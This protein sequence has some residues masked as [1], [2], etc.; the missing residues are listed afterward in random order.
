M[1]IE[2]IEHCA[3]VEKTVEQISQRTAQYKTETGRRD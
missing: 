1:Q 3:A 2:K